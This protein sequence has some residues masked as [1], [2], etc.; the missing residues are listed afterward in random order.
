VADTLRATI[1]EKRHGDRVVLSRLYIN[2][3]HGEFVAL[4]GPSGCGKTTLLHILAGLDRA[5]TGTVTAPARLGMVFQEPRLLPWRSA[6]ENIALAAPALS[7][8]AVEAALDAVGLAGHGH[9]LPRQLSLGMARR[10][11]VARALAVTPRLL[12]L[13]EPM[14][15]LDQDSAAMVRHRITDYWQTHRPMVVMVSHDPVDVADLAQRIIRI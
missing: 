3:A 12:L 13:D 2:I 11:A 15:S 4:T 10:V 6:A 9:K 7:R 1:H 5:Y 14:V 8:D